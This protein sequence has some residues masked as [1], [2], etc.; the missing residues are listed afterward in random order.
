[1][2]DMLIKLKHVV[3]MSSQVGANDRR[4]SQP[5]LI[6]ALHM[7]PPAVPHRG[8]TLTELALVP[9]PKRLPVECWQPIQS[10]LRARL[11]LHGEIRHPRRDRRRLGRRRGQAHMAIREA[12]PHC[13]ENMKMFG[14]LRLVRGL[15]RRADRGDARP[16]VRRHRHAPTGKRRAA[17]G[18]ILSISAQLP[19]RQRESSGSP[20]GA[21]SACGAHH[22]AG[23]R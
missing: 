8:Y 18:A 5:E 3:C 12:A 4:Y 14:E 1:M 15:D 13:E 7:I 22:P 10:R 23:S 2:T 9:A 17:I 6:R 16:P 19:T 21:R 11:R 20:D